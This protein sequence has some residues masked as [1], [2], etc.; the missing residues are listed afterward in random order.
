[1]GSGQVQDSEAPSAE[2][3][4]CGTSPGQIRQL[5]TCHWQRGAFNRGGQGA[6][7]Q[8]IPAASR[9]L[10]ASRGFM[11]HDRSAP[12]G[13]RHFKLAPGSGTTC[14]TSTPPAAARR[15]K[16]A[17]WEPASGGL[18]MPGG[19]QG[20]NRQAS[21]PGGRVGACQWAGGSESLLKPVIGFDGARRSAEPSSWAR[22]HG[23]HE[24]ASPLP[25]PP[26]C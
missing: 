20:A 1:M 15:G 6:S 3:S 16:V 12:A 23:S 18:S 26:V 22:D 7:G 11:T 19:G 8:A 4:S 14:D 2:P 25:G 17:S 9:S 24:A 21:P 5:K 10:P 13:G